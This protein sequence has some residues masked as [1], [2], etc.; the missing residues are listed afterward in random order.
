[1]IPKDRRHVRRQRGL[2]RWVTARGG[3]RRRRMSS[4][5]RRLLGTQHRRN[6]HRERHHNG[7]SGCH[8]RAADTPGSP[9]V[10]NWRAGRRFPWD[11]VFLSSTNGALPVV[12][13]RCARAVCP[14]RAK[15]VR[16]TCQ[17]DAGDRSSTGKVQHSRRSRVQSV[18][19]SA[20]PQA[21]LPR[22]THRLAHIMRI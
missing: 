19:H 20:T 21:S 12:A 10:T 3:A 5:S 7:R 22:R 2:C 9:R 15:A 4:V 6:H 18:R 13:A 16:W 14:D 1:M 8:A 17:Q 11:R